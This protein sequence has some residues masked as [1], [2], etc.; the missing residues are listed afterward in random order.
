MGCN[1]KNKNTDM[2]KKTKT[3]TTLNVQPVVAV[4]YEEVLNIENML[5]DINTNQAKRAVIQ[6]F[7]RINFGEVL[8][9]YCDLNCQNRLKERI[10]KLK[11]DLK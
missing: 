2:A 6:E 10:Q 8:M 3:P 9:N 5:G 4:S 1:C 7:V 11:Q